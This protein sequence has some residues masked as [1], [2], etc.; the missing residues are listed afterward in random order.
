MQNVT[1]PRAGVCHSKCHSPHHFIPSTGRK[2][3]KSCHFS[4]A[5]CHPKAHELHCKSCPSATSLLRNADNATLASDVA[6]G[7]IPATGG[8]CIVS[9]PQPFSATLQGDGS[10]VCLVP[11]ATPSPTATRTMTSSGKLPLLGQQLLVQPVCPSLLQFDR[12]DESPGLLNTLDVAPLTHV[13][14]VV[15]LSPNCSEGD[16]YCVS[17]RLRSKTEE[18]RRQVA[19]DGQRRRLLGRLPL[20]RPRGFH[21]AGPQRLDQHA[22][23]RRCWMQLGVELL[24]QDDEH[25]RLR[26]CSRYSDHDGC[27]F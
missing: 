20:H 3:C 19:D 12:V 11:P 27:V 4:C 2:V 21:N 9:C 5:S 24:P 18:P 14:P 10:F 22:R 26:R 17:S 6:S 8:R 25:G 7:S 23:R 16:G 15:P 13:V 1:G